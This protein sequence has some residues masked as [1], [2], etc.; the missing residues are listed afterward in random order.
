MSSAL[1]TQKHHTD[2]F[3]CFVLCRP[4]ETYELMTCDLQPIWRNAKSKWKTWI[5]SMTP[6]NHVIFEGFQ[7]Y[8]IRCT[9]AHQRYNKSANLGGD[10]YTPSPSSR[11][12]YYIHRYI[13]GNPWQYQRLF[14]RGLAPAK[15]IMGG[16]STLVNYYVWS[17]FLPLMFLAGSVPGSPFGFVTRPPEHLTWAPSQWPTMKNVQCELV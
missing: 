1:S 17:V 7:R 6:F 15:L 4:S 5:C 3:F 2:F 9:V 14:V 8:V 12:V 13:M 10:D 16:L 11:S